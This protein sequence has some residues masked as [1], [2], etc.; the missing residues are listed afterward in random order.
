MISEKS[1]LSQYQSLVGDLLFFLDLYPTMDAYRQADILRQVDQLVTTRQSLPNSLD[2]FG[3][4]NRLWL[5]RE[6]F[7]RVYGIDVASFLALTNPLQPFGH[8]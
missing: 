8:R 6:D 5:Q 7:Q 4:D 2:A 3:M 1:L